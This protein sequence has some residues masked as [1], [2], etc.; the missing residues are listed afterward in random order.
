MCPKVLK[1][2]FG[3]ADIESM[4]WMK[5]SKGCQLAVQKKDGGV[6]NFLGFRDQVRFLCPSVLVQHVQE[7]LNATL[8]IFQHCASL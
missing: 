2:A 1:F 7:S 4:T 8:F 3:Y 5:V 6:V